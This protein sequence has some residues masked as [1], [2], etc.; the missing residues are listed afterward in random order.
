MSSI[1][2]PVVSP[3]R[4][5]VRPL[6][7]ASV[8]DAVHPVLIDDAHL[9]DRTVIR[10]RQLE[11]RIRRRLRIEVHC[12]HENRRGLG[13]DRAPHAA[14]IHDGDFASFLGHRNSVGEDAATKP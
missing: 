6:P 7:Q 8:I 4:L 5:V 3:R 13:L 11:R 9:V 2:P 10:P 14:A 1:R 12:G